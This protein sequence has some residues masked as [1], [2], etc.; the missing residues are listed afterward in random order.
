MKRPLPVSCFVVSFSYLTCEMSALWFLVFLFEYEVSATQHLSEHDARKWC[1]P[2][3]S[4]I[5]SRSCLGSLEQLL[6]FRMALRHDCYVYFMAISV[7]RNSAHGMAKDL[8]CW[9]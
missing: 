7:F 4:S 6:F 8:A 2:R 9:Q 1:H 5:S 3:K